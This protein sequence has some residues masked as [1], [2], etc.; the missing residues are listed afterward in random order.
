MAAA[1]GGKSLKDCPSNLKEAIDWILRVTGKD[2]NSSGSQS[3]TQQLATAVT[4]LLDDV[5]PHEPE[6]R[7]KSDEIK[8]ALKSDSSTGLI[9]NL[10]DGLAKFIGYQNSNSGSDIGTDGIAVKGQPH[11]SRELAKEFKYGFATYKY[12]YILSYPKSADWNRDFSSSVT[13]HPK[14]AKIFLSCVPMLFYGLGLLYWRCRSGGGW[15]KAKV[16]HSNS[17]LRYFLSSQGFGKE[18]LQDKEGSHVVSN[19]L[20]TFKELKG[21]ISNAH[22]L[23]DYFQNFHNR[24]NEATKQEASVTA[25]KLKEHCLSALFYLCRYYFTGKHIIQSNNPSIKCRPPSSI[26]TMLYW[27]S[28]LTITPQFGDLLKHFITLVPDDFNVAISGSS[29][30]K[31]KLTAD[32]LMGH[33]ITS[34]LSSSW[35]LGTIQGSGGSEKPLLHEI[36]SNTENLQYPSLVAG[37]FNTLSSYSYALQFQLGFLMRQCRFTYGDACGWQQCKYGGSDSSSYVVNSYLCPSNGN[38]CNNSNSPPPSFPHRYLKG[39]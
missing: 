33:L 21:A 4:G 31:E 2:G 39:F 24:L 9:E 12:G 38:G 26:R 23:I 14:A 37:L 35:V 7:K 34:C 10:A 18:E 11:E 32:D 20:N 6:L 17:S 15:E 1:G 25:E 28:G 27:L 3:G 36:F 16:N 5:K 13:D 19:A 22:S 29:K 30:Q 8:K